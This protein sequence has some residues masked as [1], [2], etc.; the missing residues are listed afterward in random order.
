[1]ARPNGVASTLQ[2]ECHLTTI[3]MAVGV[4]SP[5]ST[6]V[7]NSLTLDQRSFSE[8]TNRAETS[9]LWVL[10]SNPVIMDKPIIS[11]KSTKITVS[12]EN[13]QPEVNKR[14]L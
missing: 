7:T 2:D 5:G 8:S 1:M 4:K 3:A 11:E 12:R 13:Q 6:L 10:F 9:K 14:G